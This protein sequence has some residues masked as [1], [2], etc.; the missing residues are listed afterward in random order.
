MSKPTQFFFVLLAVAVSLFLFH[1]PCKSM[2]LDAV[3]PFATK[4]RIV[5]N[6]EEVVILLYDSP[7][8]R[9]FV[10]LLPLSVTFRD[11]AG[12]EK[13]ADLPRKL[14]T[15]GGLSGDEVEGDFA[16]YAPWGNMA[17]FYTGFGQGSGLHILGRIESGKEWLAGQKRDFSARIETFE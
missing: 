10:S 2:S 4:I 12:E 5:S 14:T 3:K 9:D 16:Y 6:H 8:S 7:V 13:I 1:T 17:A 11:Y 15:Q